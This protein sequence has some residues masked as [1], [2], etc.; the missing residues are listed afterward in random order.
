MAEALGRLTGRLD[1]PAAES[2]FW[3]LRAF[4]W[5]LLTDCRAPRALMQDRGEAFAKVVQCWHGI[6]LSTL[7][8]QPLK[9]ALDALRQID[10]SPLLHALREIF[11]DENWRPNLEATVLIPYG[12]YERVARR[13]AEETTSALAND[14]FA[15][16]R[17]TTLSEARSQAIE[18]DQAVFVG[19]PKAFGQSVVTC[20][21]AGISHFVYYDF[22]RVEYENAGW[23]HSFSVLSADLPE[24][25]WMSFERVVHDSFALPLGDPNAPITTSEH[26]AIED[27]VYPPLRFRQLVQNAQV[28]LGDQDE[29]EPCTCVL[30]E[31]DFW[32]ALPGQARIMVRDRKGWTSRSVEPNELEPG[33]LLLLH[34]E[35]SQDLAQ[36]TISAVELTNSAGIDSWR[37][38]QGLARSEIEERGW[39]AF[40]RELLD[41]GVKA[42]YRYWFEEG[43]LGPREEPMFL[44]LCDAVGLGE[45]E[46]VEA[47]T[48]VRAWRGYRISAGHQIADRF[49]VEAARTLQ[50][51]E[52][53]PESNDRE[54]PPMIPINLPE[55][56]FGSQCVCRVV[57]ILGEDFLPASRSRRVLTPWGV[58]WHG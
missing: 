2:A 23:P 25:H 3:Q 11:E 5:D 38:A 42:P 6:G 55:K 18:C 46:A 34:L 16:V 36:E 4:R 57:G 45:D 53:S 44:A 28:E 1:E 20:P 37:S 51:L 29:A 17:A 27:E 32:T 35:E 9:T 54:P 19:S 49:A 7:Q 21:I 39:E 48:A 40:S 12:R 26:E 15:G 30:L 43:R 47:L 33:D 10:E 14:R 24:P 56:H 50:R 58:P 13:R 31:D 8:L 22:I 52:L 41:A